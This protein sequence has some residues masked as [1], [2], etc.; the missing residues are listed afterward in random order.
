MRE[1][2]G[3][4]ATHFSAMYEI[5]P[6]KACIDEAAADCRACMHR[7][8]ISIGREVGSGEGDSPNRKKSRAA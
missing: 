5:Y 2:P 1:P 6:A 3:V 4:R 8:I 7:R